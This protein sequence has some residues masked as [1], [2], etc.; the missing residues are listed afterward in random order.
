METPPSLIN[1]VTHIQKTRF[2]RMKY[3][4]KYIFAAFIGLLS[5]ALMTHL[6]LKLFPT[7]LSNYSDQLQTALQQESSQLSSLI[8][9][10]S[11]INAIIQSFE[12]PENADS[13]IAVVDF[14]ELS[15]QSFSLLIYQE[16]EIKFWSNNRV[17]PSQHDLNDIPNSPEQKLIK[18][19]NGYYLAQQK[20]YTT[21]DHQY[22]VV[23][24]LP[25][26]SDYAIQSEFLINEFLYVR[27]YPS[28]IAISDTL[29]GALVRDI[30]QTPLFA[31]E[32]PPTIR[33]FKYQVLL[34][35]FYFLTGI[36][37]LT[38]IQQVSRH[39][40]QRFNPW[41]GGLFLLT[42]VGGA[43]MALYQIPLPQW[44]D[45]INFIQDITHIYVQGGTLADLMINAVIVL[46]MVV[47]FHREFNVKP[48]VHLSNPI[49]VGLLTINYSIILACLLFLVQIIKSLVLESNLVF[50]FDNILK[51]NFY[52][53]LALISTSLLMMA[54][55]LFTHKMMRTTQF[56][57]VPFL[58][59]FA[60]LISATALMI[61][62]MWLFDLQIPVWGL[63]LGAVIYIFTYE[64]FLE[65][66]IQGFTWLVVWVS[67]FSLFSAALLFK[68]NLDKDQQNR[69]QFAK[70]LS[71]MED[72]QTVSVFED[73]Q[74]TLQQSEAMH[75]AASGYSI[76][77]SDPV[78]EA[79]IVLDSILGN[80]EHISSRFSF[81]QLDKEAYHQEQDSLAKI[82]GFQVLSATGVAAKLA[83]FGTFEYLLPLKWPAS[84][85]S[86][87]K[88][89]MTLLF[90]PINRQPSKVYSELL[91][92]SNTNQDTAI[93][94]Y[95]YQIYNNETALQ[96]SDILN[97]EEWSKAQEL[98]Q[99]G[100]LNYL[101]SERADLLYKTDNGD[102]ILV[103]KQLGGII[104][105]VSLFSYLFVLNILIL[106]I[107][108][109][110]NYLFKAFPTAL[111]F[112]IIGHPSLKNRIQTAVVM[113]IIGSFIVIALITAA[114]FRNSSS[115]YHYKRL[116]RKVEAVVE[117]LQY[118][119]RENN[120]EDLDFDELASSA[121]DIHNMD[122][123]IYDLEG[124]LIA[125]SANRMLES[126]IISPV[127]D[128][129][130]YHALNVSEGIRIIDE[131]L[132]RLTYQAAYKPLVLNSNEVVAFVG[133]PYYSR[134]RDLS[135]DV[136]DFMSTILNAYV[137]LF[138]F[139]G[140]IAIL[141]ANSITKPLAE[142][143][144]KLEG[145]GLGKNEPI[146]WET[147]DELGKL[148]EQYN[149]MTYK[150]E[151]HTEK[152]KV[153]ER[154]DAWR[155]MAKQIAH[156]IKNPLT[157]MKL[158]IQY[159]MHA[160]KANPEHIAPML[161]RVSTTLIDQ[162]DGLSRIASEFSNFAK[163]PQAENDRFTINQLLESV[164]DLF[165]KQADGNVQ[166][167]L[168]LPTEEFDVYADKD[169]LMRVLNNLVKNAIQAIPEDRAGLV[170]I[171][172][173]HIEEKEQLLISVEDNGTGISPKMQEKVFFP[174]FT[175]KNSGMGLGLA[176]SKNIIE[177]AHGNIYFETEVG[178]G[179]TFYVELP[180]LMAESSR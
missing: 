72:L 175:T 4:P 102:F 62:I 99:N 75:K 126:G 56:I 17:I 46:W 68:Y 61:P 95:Q 20:K 150:L 154:E 171:K 77:P 143:G 131:N 80:F 89:E 24:L 96:Q 138:L 168:D 18:L 153:S 159:L 162:I 178:K 1:Q 54:M 83:E 63:M 26:R 60:A 37:L 114:F 34:F 78:F 167:F 100:Y 110:I 2:Y 121:S 177:A 44:F 39:F 166:L 69:L 123:N 79:S 122:V 52:S 144:E 53:V 127:M 112:E 32:G 124:H 55:F 129:R 73:L 173:K 156:E 116:Q 119:L 90:R 74:L 28:N 155:E 14:N 85:D 174:N 113:L 142:I 86:L 71:N 57:K 15:Q 169:H 148:I 164:Y 108:N 105:P 118:E 106:V 93:Q 139:A 9:D 16:N 134:N 67:G 33:P 49:N 111:G 133:L 140:I 98:R 179:T 97:E 3:W 22:Q 137:F 170:I 109:L 30:N 48:P 158:N 43:R 160:Y 135:N 151:A 128:S 64:L 27:N 161:K 163:M 107:F 82:L 172:L 92:L 136:Y 23:G 5:I 115:E 51:F 125:S 45:R 35:L 81:D 141:V 50:D 70:R 176:I 165:Q 157:P 147:N 40:S 36:A 87:F 88:A 47:F 117:N 13:Y 21:S 6:V 31:I 8:N 145:L 101:N 29:A 103:R 7:P 120:P 84:G 94:T 91:L 180:R 130:A 149:Q 104:K 38:L 42:T 132:G 58:Y 12:S 19:R 25:I 10:E 41:V 76:E 59:K 146:K 65:H 66:K 152:L 11:Y